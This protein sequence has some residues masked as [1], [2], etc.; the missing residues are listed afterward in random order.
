MKPRRIIGWIA[1]IP[2]FVFWLLAIGSASNAGFSAD[3]YA[4]QMMVM[5]GAISTIAALL[6]NLDVLNL[7]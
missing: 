5:G 2:A 4:F 1:I 3:A 7:V 6:L